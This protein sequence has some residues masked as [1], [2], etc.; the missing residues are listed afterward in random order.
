M[1]LIFQN[2]NTINISFAFLSLNGG[3]Y[4]GTFSF[5]NHTFYEN[6][7]NFFYFVPAEHTLQAP[8]WLP[9]QPLWLA[10]QSSGTIS[11]QRQ[12]I[13]QQLSQ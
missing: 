8:D 11:V 7:Y 4:V 1:E 2:S 10:R 5:Q 12:E 6:G 9:K 3:Q 13:R